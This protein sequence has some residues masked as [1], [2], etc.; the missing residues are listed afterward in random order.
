[1]DLVQLKKSVNNKRFDRAA[2]NVPRSG[3]ELGPSSVV[4]KDGS[5]R[6]DSSRPFERR[7]KIF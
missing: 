1:M 5:S 2:G 3:M 6:K 4:R 7:K